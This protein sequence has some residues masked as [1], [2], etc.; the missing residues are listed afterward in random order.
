M[1]KRV[2]TS[3]I[4]LLSVVLIAMAYQPA[5]SKVAGPCS[6][7][8]TMHNS[9]NGSAMALTGSTGWNGSSLQ[10]T[11]TDTPNDQLLVASCVGCH[12][13]T[14]S[15]TIIDLGDGSRIP[16]VFNTGGYPVDSLAGGNFYWVSMGGAENDEK[17]HNVEGISG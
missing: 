13:A 11:P 7:C 15:E 8:H 9:Q 10:G 6:N 4:F 17:G 5:L 16:I 14:T 2:F 12:T 1:K 3:E